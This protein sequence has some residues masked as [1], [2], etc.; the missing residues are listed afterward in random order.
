MAVGTYFIKGVLMLQGKAAVGDF[1]HF[2]FPSCRQGV[3]QHPQ[4]P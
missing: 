4:H 3:L 2:K 1:Y